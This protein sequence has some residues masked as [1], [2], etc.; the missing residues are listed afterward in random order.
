[1]VAALLPKYAPPRRP[2]RQPRRWPKPNGAGQNSSAPPT[3]LRVAARAADPAPLLARAGTPSACPAPSR[4]TSGASPRRT[5]S[6]TSCV[7]ARPLP[8][9]RSAQRSPIQLSRRS[10]VPCRA[11]GPQHGV[12]QPGGQDPGLHPRCA[13][14]PP[15]PVSVGPCSAQPPRE[16]NTFRIS[17][18]FSFP[19]STS[20]FHTTLL[21]S[22]TARRP[23]DA[24]PPSPAGSPAPPPC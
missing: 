5:A 18:F 7:P 20:P 4:T 16:P 9:R 1:M 13:R 19:P 21:A 11:G 22:H 14:L 8:S 10:A 2:A 23:P 15:L 3:P 17:H 24:L 6:S 12:C